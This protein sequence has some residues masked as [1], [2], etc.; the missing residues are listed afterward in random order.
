MVV[1]EVGVGAREVGRGYGRV[2]DYCEDT[3]E[4]QL[5][6]EPVEAAH[7][8]CDGGVG[9]DQSCCCGHGVCKCENDVREQRREMQMVVVPVKNTEEGL[10]YGEPLL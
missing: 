3:N 7:E 8:E 5:D 2:D 6:A 4:C 1:V 10:S 9:G